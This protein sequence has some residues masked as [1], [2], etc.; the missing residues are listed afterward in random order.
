MA[1]SKFISF[2][3]PVFLITVPG[4]HRGRARAV[5]GAARTKNVDCDADG[6][7]IGTAATEQSKF[8]GSKMP[9]E[10]G[11]AAAAYST[12]IPD[13]RVFPSVRN[14]MSLRHLQ[15]VGHH[16]GCQR[17]SMQQTDVAVHRDER[18]VEKHACR[19]SS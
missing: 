4:S 13:F 12:A 10:G 3:S 16:S 11:T 7:A 1:V 15:P 18:P 19:I 14:I 2:G 5:H 8:S 9:P 6:Q 17:A